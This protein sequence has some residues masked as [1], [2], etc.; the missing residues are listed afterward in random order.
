VSDDPYDW[1][2]PDGDQARWSDADWLRSMARS[3]FVIEDIARA[4]KIADWLSFLSETVAALRADLNETAKAVA[5]DV[6]AERDHLKAILAKIRERTTDW[7]DV[8]TALDALDAVGD[9]LAGRR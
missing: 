1:K 7:Q 8:G 9:I 2:D 6:V 4:D 3:N 5:A